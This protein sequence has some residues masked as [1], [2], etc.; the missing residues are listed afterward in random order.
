MLNY[1]RLTICRKGRSIIRELKRQRNSMWYHRLLL[2]HD[3]DTVTVMSLTEKGQAI[4]NNFL[5]L[6]PKVAVQKPHDQ[7]DYCLTV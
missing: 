2:R 6:K 4:K 5:F 1:V 3:K 7:H